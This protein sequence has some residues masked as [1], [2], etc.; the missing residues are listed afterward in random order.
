M[1]QENRETGEQTSDSEILNSGNLFLFRTKLCASKGLRGF[2]QR[3]KHSMI[4]LPVHGGH[5]DEEQ[6]WR[7]RFESECARGDGPNVLDSYKTLKESIIHMAYFNYN[8]FH[9]V[10]DTSIGLV[11]SC[12][13]VLSQLH[14]CNRGS[15]FFLFHIDHQRYEARFKESFQAQEASSG[16][17]TWTWASNFNIDKHWRH[18][19]HAIHS[20]LWL[21]VGWVCKHTSCR[22]HQCECSASPFASLGID[23]LSSSR[24]PITSDS[25]PRFPLWR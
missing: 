1:I 15:V 2:V 16:F 3:V 7:T 10:K 6:D 4:F 19:S 13:C 24:P 23:L 9:H 18:W 25:L 17:H 14:L 8:S 11:S 22:W 21:W 5:W 20:C 12:D